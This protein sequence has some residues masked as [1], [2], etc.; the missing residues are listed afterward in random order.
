MSSADPKL[1]HPIRVG[2]VNLQHRIALAPLT[3]CRAN[4]KHVHSDY[5]VEYYSQRASVPGTLLITEATFIARQAGGNTN[6]PGIWSDEQVEA[7][8]KVGGEIF[9]FC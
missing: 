1:F 6:V 5:A 2:N 8:K 4:A 9:F 3:R 7:W